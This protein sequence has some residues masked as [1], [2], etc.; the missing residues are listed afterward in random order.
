MTRPILNGR[1]CHRRCRRSNRIDRSSSHAATIRRHSHLSVRSPIRPIRSTWSCRSHCCGSCPGRQR[2]LLFPWCCALWL[3][4]KRGRVAAV[5]V[6]ALRREVVAPARSKWVH[7][8]AAPPG[9]GWMNRC[10]RSPC[11][12]R[13]GQLGNRACARGHR[14]L[15][16][17]PPARRL[18]PRSLHRGVPPR[19]RG[20]SSKSGSRRTEGAVSASCASTS[21][22]CQSTA[23]LSAARFF[24]PIVRP[25]VARRTMRRRGQ[26]GLGA[27]EQGSERSEVRLRTCKGAPAHST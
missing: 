23:S 14:W 17:A 12:V 19:Q 11:A 16:G 1:C 22:A 24:L 10:Q 15:Q 20:S 6:R 8:R 2:H 13:I 18:L 5:P 3:I 27:R 25:F 26:S 7:S 9:H 4:R 21:S